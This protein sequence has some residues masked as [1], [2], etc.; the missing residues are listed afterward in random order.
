N[1]SWTTTKRSSRS[2]PF[3][4]PFEF[5]VTA[6]GLQFHT[7]KLLTGGESSS[8]NALPSSF[9]LTVL[10]LAPTGIRSGRLTAFLFHLKWELAESSSPPPDFPQA[11]IIAGRHVIVR[12]IIPPFEFLVSPYPRRI[13]EG[14]SL[15]KRRAR[16]TISSP[17]IP[18]IAAARDG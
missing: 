18:V 15:A 16:E 1:C 11:P 2:S 13:D 6:T 10:G 9:M 7:I 17:G 5:G 14:C 8:T 3:L 4:T 12:A